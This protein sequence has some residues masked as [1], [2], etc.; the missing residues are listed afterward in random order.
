MPKTYDLC[1]QGIRG[2]IIE[3]RRVHWLL[4]LEL[5]TRKMEI[6]LA[7]TVEETRKH[8]TSAWRFY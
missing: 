7:E 6:I 1:L 5:E 8:M 3:E 4:Q 2:V